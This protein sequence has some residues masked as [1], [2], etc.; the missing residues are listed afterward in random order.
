MA[1]M[2][3]CGC[4][5]AVGLVW[6]FAEKLCVRSLSSTSIAFKSNWSLMRSMSFDNDS[7]VPH[8]SP[9]VF[10]VQVFFVCIGEQGT[11]NRFPKV[12]MLELSSLEAC[13]VHSFVCS[14]QVVSPSRIDSAYYMTR[15]AGWPRVD[16]QRFHL[17]WLPWLSAGDKGTQGS[18]SITYQACACSPPWCFHSKRMWSEQIWMLRK[19]RW[20]SAESFRTLTIGG[21]G[22]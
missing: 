14:L 9:S 13:F 19:N 21:H 7:I 20:S 18:R 3:N 2:I 4:S 17:R 10:G 1:V 11:T 15:P 16:E 22:K 12:D 5:G 8:N 6:T